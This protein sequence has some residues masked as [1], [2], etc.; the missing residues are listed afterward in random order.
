MNIGRCISPDAANEPFGGKL[1]N[2]GKILASAGEGTPTGDPL[3]DAV[4]ADDG[5]FFG[6]RDI[7]FLEARENEERK[8]IVDGENGGGARLLVQQPFQ[9]GTAGDRFG[10]E[11]GIVVDD[12]G[13]EVIFLQGAAVSGD[14][15]VNRVGRV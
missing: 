6:D 1:P 10:S 13:P 9:G 3:K 8:R 11:S 15:F 12:G 5:D 7:H 14:A 2:A 4:E